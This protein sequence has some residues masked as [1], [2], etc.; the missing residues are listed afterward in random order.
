[1]L[2]SYLDRL[3]GGALAMERGSEVRR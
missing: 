3:S 1:M 2:G